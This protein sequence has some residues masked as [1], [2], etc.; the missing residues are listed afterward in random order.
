MSNF[1][2]IV[3]GVTGF[4]GIALGVLF[5]AAFARRVSKR[6]Q[7]LAQNLTLAGLAVGW[8]SIG[9]GA[10]WFW[11]FRLAGRP[12]FM[13]DHIIVFAIMFGRLLAGVLHVAHFI[14][15]YRDSPK[16]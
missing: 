12:E 7:G 3:H 16:S 5:A 14:V 11:A 8:L 4:L 9:G 15:A 2:E 6:G 1:V 10:L 13:T